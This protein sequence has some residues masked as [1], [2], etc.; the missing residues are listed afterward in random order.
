MRQRYRSSQSTEHV[1]VNQPV[2]TL[3]NDPLMQ[4]DAAA[5]PQCRFV[6]G[7]PDHDRSAWHMHSR[8]KELANDGDNRRNRISKIGQVATVRNR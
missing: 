2:E 5:L 8:M 3:G 6:P 1:G 7:E 4:V